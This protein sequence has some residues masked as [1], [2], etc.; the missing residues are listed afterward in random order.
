MYNNNK[1]RDETLYMIIDHSGTTPT[2]DIDAN[3]QDNRDR[4]KGF[5]GCRYHYVIT[6]EGVVQL[7]RTLDRVSPLTGV[8]D[9]QSVT[10]WLVG[11]TNIEGEAEDNFTEVQK[12]ALKELITVSR[13]SNPDLQV[14]GRKEIQ[15]Q[16]TTGPALDLTP[17][18]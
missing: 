2:I 12:E 4:A 7:G 5:Y 1:K 9:Y 17:Y 11:G 8:L 14:L 6:R 10:L 3:N 18:R 13:I 16:R 15:K